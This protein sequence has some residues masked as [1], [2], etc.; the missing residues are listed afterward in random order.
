HLAQTVRAHWGIENCMHWVLDVAF[1]EDDCRIR[2]GDAAQNFAI[3]R[4]IALNLLKNE[5][6]T[7]LGIASKRLKAGWS[8]DY[9]AKVLGLP[10]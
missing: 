8:A 2:I 7:K 1:R 6:T 4:R 9:L 5:K 10:A 3:L